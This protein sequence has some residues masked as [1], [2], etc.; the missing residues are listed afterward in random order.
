MKKMILI[1]S[2][3]TFTFPAISQQ[4]KYEKT[5]SQALAKLEDAEGREALAEAANTFERIGNAMPGEWLPFYYHAFTNMRLAMALMEEGQ[6]GECQAYVSKA[7]ESL[8]KAM[9]IEEE[10]SEIW[11]LQGLIFQ[12]RIWEDPQ[13]RGAEFSM[14]SHQALD[15][16]I[17]I[18]PENPRAYYLKGQNVFFTPSFYGGGPEAAL[19]LLEKAENLFETS[20]SGN[21]LEPN[22]GRETNRELLN[23][24]RAAKSEEKN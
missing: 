17:S 14:K 5:L 21:A 16:A 15:K 1:V 18:G 2:M 6:M 3:F 19:P 11:A 24:A 13:A 20:G 7:Q 9:A 23:R 8:D 12:G 10:N 4:T 22:W